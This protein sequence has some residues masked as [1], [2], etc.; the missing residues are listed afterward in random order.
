MLKRLKIIKKINLKNLKNSLKIIVTAVWILKNNSPHFKLVSIFPSFNG[1]ISKRREEDKKVVLT[2]LI[3]LTISKQCLRKLKMTKDTSKP[4][5][6]G[7]VR[8]QLNS[9][10][11]H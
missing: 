11:F 1:R 10:H 9:R 3:I 8:V 6:Q 7:N 2:K 4:N 5:L